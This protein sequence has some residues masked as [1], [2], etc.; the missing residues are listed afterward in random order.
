MNP[1]IKLRF[2]NFS[3]KCF[4][5][6][7]QVFVPFRASLFRDSI[8]REPQHTPGAYHWSISFN[9]PKFSR[10]VGVPGY[11]AR[12]TFEKILQIYTLNLDRCCGMIC[13]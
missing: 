8:L 13:G 10:M 5:F 6:K 3:V 9:F 4:C 1:T 2:S 7:F 11:V 12:R